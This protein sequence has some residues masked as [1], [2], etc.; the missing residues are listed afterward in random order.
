[1][2][3][4]CKNVLSGTDFFVGFDYSVVL[5]C[6]IYSGLSF[7]VPMWLTKKK[8]H[9][10]K[11]VMQI[12]RFLGTLG[13]TLSVFMMQGSLSPALFERLLPWLY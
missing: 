3:P 12:C 2:D 5:P 13:D 1:M 10:C 6:A 9:R 11:F 4:I 8:L 7:C